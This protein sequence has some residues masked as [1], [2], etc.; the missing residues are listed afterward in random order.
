MLMDLFFDGAKVSN[1]RRIHFHEFMIEVH[2]TIHAW[3]QSPSKNKDEV[4]PLPHIAREMARK[5]ALLCF[6]EFHVA[7]IAD[8]MIL[9]RLFEEFLESGVVVIATSNF[10][11]DDLLSLI[12]I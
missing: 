7:N 5:S 12:H 8:A 11:P 6:D 3:R 10:A 9:R 4:D 2:D 1:K